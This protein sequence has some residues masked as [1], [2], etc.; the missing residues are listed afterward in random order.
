MYIGSFN[1]KGKVRQVG[2]RCLMFLKLIVQ[3][4]SLLNNFKNI[5]NSTVYSLV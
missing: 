5:Y 4:V 3:T 1:R 2:T